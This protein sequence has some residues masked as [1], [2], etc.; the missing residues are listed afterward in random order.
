MTSVAIAIV[1][2]GVGLLLSALYSG[3]E[4]GMYTINRIRLDVRSAASN[5]NARRIKSLIDKP[6]RML[7]V[8]LICN[9]IANYLASYGTAMV[10]DETSFGPW[11]SIAINALCLIPILFIFGEVLPKDLFRA[12][13]DS[14]TYRYSISLSFA[15][16]LFR[17]TGVVPLVSSI[18]KIAQ[19]CL[20]TESDIE[21]TPRLRFGLLFKEGLGSG[22]IS[23]EQTSLADRVLSMRSLSVGS[24]MIPW[25]RVS[26]VNI[27]AS[28]SMRTRSLNWA[29]HT[30]LPVIDSDG[31]V[32]GVLPSIA[33]LLHT[34]E[35][36]ENLMHPALFI[37]AS[38]QVVEAITKV[39]VS[40]RSM[41]V[42]TSPDSGKPIGIV[43]LKDLVEPLVGELAAW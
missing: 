34:H 31:S 17:W 33:A 41:A 30:R 4:T 25:S 42:V 10:L 7:A 35:T 2:A 40:G 19:H 14:W 11:L 32:K 20:G 39:R 9:N 43:T 21:P 22:A 1:I 28:P 15:D 5:P 13:A 6:T 18:G 36:T 29:S 26:C 16:L 3:L 27:D 38:M 23:N 37:S 24:E 12:H 8:L